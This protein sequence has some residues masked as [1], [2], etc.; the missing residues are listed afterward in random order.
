MKHLSVSCKSLR[1]QTHRSL[2]VEQE[3][4]ISRCCRQ[5]RAF[6]FDLHHHAS[7]REFP[8]DVQ[9]SRRQVKLARSET[10]IHKPTSTV[11]STRATQFL[12]GS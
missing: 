7:F 10:Y 6:N 3:L 12:R 8:H 4:A 11:K 5:F 1:H 2:S 9:S